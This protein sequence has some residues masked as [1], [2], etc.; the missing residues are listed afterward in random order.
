MKQQ[1]LQT[2]VTATT[3][4]LLLFHLYFINDAT[5]QGIRAIRPK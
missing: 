2:I 5:F 3:I 4:T 1:L